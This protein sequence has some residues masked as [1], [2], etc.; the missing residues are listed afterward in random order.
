MAG[1]KLLYLTVIDARSTRRTS[2][3]AVLTAGS[4]ADNDN[5]DSDLVSIMCN[6]P[7]SFILSPAYC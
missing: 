2:M 5:T 3:E 7:Y 1:L 4:P 6:L